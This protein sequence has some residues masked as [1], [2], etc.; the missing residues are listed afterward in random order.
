VGKVAAAG[1]AMVVVG[2]LSLSL[3]LSLTMGSGAVVVSRVRNLN[4][5]SVLK[6][7]GNTGHANPFSTNNYYY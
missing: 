1:H 7:A 6:A 3:S 4:G 2:S 5:F